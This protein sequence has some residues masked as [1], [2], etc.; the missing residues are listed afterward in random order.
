MIHGRIRYICDAPGCRRKHYV[1]FKAG[2]YIE[3]IE[4]PEG[5]GEDADGKILCPD[6]YHPAPSVPLPEYLRDAYKIMGKT[7]ISMNSMLSVMTTLEETADKGE[8]IHVQP[9]RRENEQS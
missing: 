2:L 7:Y 9:P 5:W 1:K 8:I 3:E 6:H 4:P